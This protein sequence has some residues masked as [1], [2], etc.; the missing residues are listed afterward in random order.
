M[1]GGG[2]RTLGEN[3]K[4]TLNRHAVIGVVAAWQATP[5]RLR[6]AAASRAGR[7]KVEAPESIPQCSCVA[8]VAVRSS[9]PCR[10][11][12]MASPNEN[13]LFPIYVIR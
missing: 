9:A 10:A 6:R 8:G 7:V 5:R 4:A 11:G 2:K 3:V 12:R 1:L 13:T